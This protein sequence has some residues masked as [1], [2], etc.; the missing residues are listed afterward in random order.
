MLRNR[1]IYTKFL[2]K[3][4]EGIFSPKKETTEEGITENALNMIFYTFHTKDENV[5][6]V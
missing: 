1:K 6:E 4:E 5:K 3:T 2:I